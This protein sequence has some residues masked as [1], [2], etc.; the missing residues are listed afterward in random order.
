MPDDLQTQGSVDLNA[1]GDQPQAPGAVQ[2][3]QLSDAGYN[4][5]ELADWES[6]E[7]GKLKTA[8]FSNDEVDKHFGT[9][10]PDMSVVKAHIQNGLS[11]FNPNEPSVGEEVAQAQSGQMP[12]IADQSAAPG[13]PQFDGPAPTPDADQP[14]E[15][16]T[17]FDNIKAGLEISVP[18][19]LARGQKPDIITP[20]DAPTYMRIASQMSTL[21]GDLPVM[22]GGGVLGGVLGAP[23]GPIAAVG[24]GAGA[25]ALPAAMRDTLML[26]YQ[27]GDI[28]NFQDFWERTSAVFLDSIKQGVV[29]GATAGVGGVVGKLASPLVSA[30][31]A[32]ATK[33][34]SEIATMVTVGKAIEGQVPKLQ[35]FTDAAIAVAFMHGAIEG[36]K[37]FKGVSEKLQN[38]YAKTALTPEKVVE[39]ASKDPL[40][41]QELLSDGKEIP[42]ALKPFIEENAVPQGVKPE[43]VLQDPRLSDPEV[44]SSPKAL[45]AV[46]VDQERA[47]VLEDHL[48]EVRTAAEERI[49]EAGGAEKADSNDLEIQRQ[50]TEGLDTLKSIKDSLPES[51][52]NTI[53][54]I[55]D[56][57]TSESTTDLPKKLTETGPGLNEPDEPVSFQRRAEDKD[58]F[59]LNERGA[60]GSDPP[61]PKTPLE[62]AQ[63]KI[64]ARIESRPEPQSERPTWNKFVEDWID[65][66]DPFKRLVDKLTG[67]EELKA[68]LDPYK[69]MRLVTGAKGKASYFFKYGTFDFDTL[70]KTGDSLSKI[71]GPFEGDKEGLNA[72]LASSRVL[73]LEGRG[74]EHGFDLEAAKK[75]VDEGS[76]YKAT[77]DKLVDY[78]NRV[79]KY[80]KDSGRISEDAYQNMLEANK[81]YVPFF[82]ISEEGEAVGGNGGSLQGKAI[83]KIEGSANKIVDPIESVVRNTLSYIKLAEE[84]RAMTALADLAKISPMGEEL[85]KPA[86]GGGQLKENEI[87]VFKNGEMSKY[88]VEPDVA[89]AYR[90]M[91]GNS[92]ELGWFWKYAIVGPAK[93]LR[94]TLTLT[95]DFMARH[96]IRYELTSS[97]LGK[98]NGIPVWDSLKGFGDALFK[99]EAYQDWLKSGSVADSFAEMDNHYIEK[100]VWELNKKTGFIDAMQNVVRH[101]LDSI[102]VGAELLDASIRIANFKRVAGDNPSANDIFEGGYESRNSPVDNQRIGA[103]MQAWNQITAFL[104]LHVQG[105]DRAVE[106]FKERPIAT[107]TRVG[108][109][110]TLP[111]LY[112]WW[113]NHEDPRYAEIPQWEKD[114]AWIIMTPNHI[115]RIPK[116]FELGI[117]FGSLPERVLDGF[118]SKNPNAFKGFGD[119]LMK[120]FAPNILPTS[121]VPIVEHFAN[122][123]TLTNRN[124]ISAPMEKLAPELQYTEY[125]TEASKMI[126]HAIQQ[127]PWIGKWGPDENH[128]LASPLVVQNYIRAW[129][130][131]LGTYALKMADAALIKS[132]AVPD[133]K[134]ADT[135]LAQMPFIKAF[136]VQYPNASAESIQDLYDEAK[137]HETMKASFDAAATTQNIKVMKE[138]Q[139]DPEFQEKMIPLTGAVT[140]LTRQS[141]TIKLID[142]NLNIPTSQKRQMID[143]IYSGMITTAHVTMESIRKK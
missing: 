22:L 14:K 127:I 41:R 13:L 58:P 60:I 84:N 125:T 142:Q 140:A 86:E 4:G 70:E 94:S 40:T 133:P 63:D 25:F 131:N 19:L 109:G 105:L 9:V 55:H 92:Q 29:G 108:A 102:R 72:Y 77:A 24:A 12:Q 67:G 116:P 3:Q 76:K 123:S 103:Q 26:H 32:T 6:G 28:Q 97:Q 42:T 11:T 128:A 38:I 90:S 132:G 88:E 43:T 114:L 15:A 115:F 113:A 23:G 45:S 79:L 65:K 69:L 7:R 17:F 1:P 80:L 120:G 99:T 36:P 57:D 51:S 62:E 16:K 34:A 96:A 130:G 27:K 39:Q 143:Q 107:L 50:T 74:I 122:R 68:S 118:Y 35:D 134:H 78:Q 18:G 87:A 59:G 21:A 52:E 10:K 66:L 53:P 93:L 112:L 8:G 135:P 119:T 73:E 54:S 121:A 81:Q 75:V 124:L 95:P 106:A 31:A 129:S 110:I 20:A 56:T 44:L 33:L 100:N 101:P 82:R 61:K 136:L 137:K 111:S 37:S 91:D 141:N 139:A 89:R 71:L 47:S 85:M 2:R 138:L 126:G 64:L 5:Q 117:I 49:K 104:N 98:Y 83:H 46:V 30:G 48:T